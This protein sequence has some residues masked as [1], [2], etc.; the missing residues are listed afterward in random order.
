MNIRE[1]RAILFSSIEGGNS[2]WSREIETFGPCALIERVNSGLYD[3]IKYEKTISKIR[4]TSA[5]YVMSAIEQ[6][7]SAF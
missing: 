4:N 6:T 3:P 2:F 1:A 5:D 7:H